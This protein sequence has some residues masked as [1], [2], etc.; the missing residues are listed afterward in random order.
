MPA[1]YPPPKPSY[2]SQYKGKLICSSKSFVQPS[3]V[4]DCSG[5][6][7]IG[8]GTYIG[9]RV[10]II[11]HIH[12]I[13]PKNKTRLQVMNDKDYT[14]PVNLLIEA[15]VLINQDVLILPQVRKIGKGAY[16]GARAVVTKDI[17][18]Y[19]IWAGNPA[20]KVGER[21]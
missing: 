15:D 8:E 6:V 13:P 10:R 14:Q 5:N 2:W 4:I 3:A 16:I 18:P 9:H 7:T 20:R 17:P 12:K 1:P 11:T 19:E 21:K